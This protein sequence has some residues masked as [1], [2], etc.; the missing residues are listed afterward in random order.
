MPKTPGHYL[1]RVDGQDT[2]LYVGRSLQPV[3]RLRQHVTIKGLNEIGTFG[4]VIYCNLP[5]SLFWQV[6]LYTLVD[7]QAIVCAYYRSDLFADPP[8]IREERYHDYQQFA[9]A[10]PNEQYYNFYH[11]HTGFLS[12]AEAAFI[13]RYQPCVNIALHSVQPTYPQAL[14]PPQCYF[15]RFPDPQK[16]RAFLRQHIA[17]VKVT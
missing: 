7:C 12:D 9:C 15:A 16:A 2:R 10:D 5:D 1:Y 17:R 11:H 3:K 6:R 8:D 4:K 14:Q 13:W